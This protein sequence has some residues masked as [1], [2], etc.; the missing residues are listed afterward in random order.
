MCKA[1]VIASAIM[2]GACVAPVSAASSQES[3]AAPPAISRADSDSAIPSLATVRAQLDSAERMAVAAESTYR[4]RLR[5]LR[6]QRGGDTVRVGP[7]RIAFMPEDFP[8]VQRRAAIEGLKDAIESLDHRFGADGVTL[9]DSALFQVQRYSN[10]FF[11]FTM[12]SVPGVFQWH[13]LGRSVQ[14]DE[15]EAFALRKAAVT[16]PAVAPVL[17]R[18]SGLNTSLGDNDDAFE[19]VAGELALSRSSAGRRCYTGDIAACRALFAEPASNA[20]ALALWFEPE[21]Y[22]SIVEFGTRSIAK[23][24]SV[25]QAA[26]VRCLEGDNASCERLVTQLPINNPHSAQVRLTLTEH[27]L[28]IAPRNALAVLA[29]TDSS[30]SPVAAL[31]RAAGVSEDSL[32]AGWQQRAVETFEAGRPSPLLLVA[33]TAMWGFLLLELAIRR[34]PL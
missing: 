28:D 32:V 29:A 3:S 1:R 31:A 34:R 18:F 22:R 5:E 7:V 14:S 17:A 21:D 4:R 11:G 15:V 12:I 30:A 10:R 27:A 24:D 6:V 2:L 13:R 8:A 19:Q 16:L 20:E 33:S 23:D 9:L 26:L 25:A